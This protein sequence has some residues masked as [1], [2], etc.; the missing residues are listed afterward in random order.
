MTD[1]FEKLRDH[2]GSMAPESGQWNALSGRLN[3][4]RRRI[5]GMWFFAGLVGLMGIGS[6]LYWT[7]PNESE[8]LF[9][10][11][12]TEPSSSDLNSDNKT[13]NLKNGV[14]ITQSPQTNEQTGDRNHEKSSLVENDNTKSS[15]SG[16]IALKSND[17]V[18]AGHSKTS[19]D[20]NNQT[21][22]FTYQT[23]VAVMASNKEDQNALQE[24]NT[25]TS[26]RIFA[27]GPFFAEMPNGLFLI[28]H[29]SLIKNR[30]LL[31]TETPP[32]KVKPTRE[33]SLWT[34]LGVGVLGDLQKSSN[35]QLASGFLAFQYD[36]KPPF[37][38]AVRVGLTS[39][40]DHQ[41][42][43]VY[44]YSEV[45]LTRR[46][47]TATY[48]ALNVNY[49]HLAPMLTSAINEKHLLSIGGF[50][51]RIYQARG[52]KANSNIALESSAK[53]WGYH[54][55]LNPA[56]YG[57][58]AQYDYALTE[59]IK[60]GVNLQYGLSNR[61]NATYFPN[62]ASAYRRDL[63]LTLQKRIR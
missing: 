34:G 36:F 57:I 6:L 44:T 53:G 42:E 20:K 47:V 5:V 48:S 13:E 51:N 46:E 21:G 8:R 9:S 22:N 25:N 16:S 37:G 23:Q 50:Y 27:E 43:Y 54:G 17:I 56:E 58:S 31:A 14:A 61:L 30:A 63:R 40:F 55:L 52:E 60:L 28:G 15:L 1:P 49:I 11:K 62:G 4:R 38:V 35:A 2:E 39:E 41:L 32:I 12:L 59:Q 10:E 33:M 18:N 24:G 19:I 29:K 3:R 45:F 7:T 26:L